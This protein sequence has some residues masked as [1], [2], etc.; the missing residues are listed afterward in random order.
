MTSTICAARQI[1]RRAV[2]PEPV[3]A[4]WLEDF[5]RLFE[6]E[7]PEPQCPAAKAVEGVN[8]Q[9]VDSNRFQVRQP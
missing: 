7:F 6:D 2:N 8:H 4:E 1:Q 9:R 5:R 3:G